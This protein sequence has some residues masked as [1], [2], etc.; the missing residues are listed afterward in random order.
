[1]N[2][3]FT[4]HLSPSGGHTRP[5][6]AFTLVELTAVMAVI[7]ILIGLLLPG[8]L[9]ARER[10]RRVQCTNNLM[11]L[12]LAMHTYHNFFERLPSGTINAT[13]PILSFPSGY[14]FNWISGIL[15]YLEER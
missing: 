6:W 12:G 8:I 10:A 3:R 15:P 7:G 5:R 13:G 1:M 14:H 9:S 2:S 11:Q 4:T